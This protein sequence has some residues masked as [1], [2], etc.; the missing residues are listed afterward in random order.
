MGIFDKLTGKKERKSSSFN[1]FNNNASKDKIN[2]FQTR[3]KLNVQ[4]QMGDQLYE[5][6]TIA[7]EN[8]KFHRMQIEKDEDNRGIYSVFVG[9]PSEKSKTTYYGN[10]NGYLVIQV[11]VN[12]RNLG[13]ELV[14]NYSDREVK[15]YSLRDINTAKKDISRYVSNYVRK[16]EFGN[17]E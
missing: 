15:I 6:I 13:S 3:N 11:N 16:P 10:I 17:K 9:I 14:V 7:V 8:N 4:M 2:E 12:I 5:V 1:S